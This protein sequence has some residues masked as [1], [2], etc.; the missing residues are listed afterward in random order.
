MAAENSARSTLCCSQRK[1][2]MHSCR[3]FDTNFW[4]QNVAVGHFKATNGCFEW[5]SWLLSKALPFEFLLRSNN[6]TY[7]TARQTQSNAE[8]MC[9]IEDWIKTVIQFGWFLELKLADDAVGN[10]SYTV[11]MKWDCW[12]LENSIGL[13]LDKV[14]FMA[15]ELKFI[16]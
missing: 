4:I 6:L 9:K 14:E 7:T 13:I 12:E 10:V 2:S 16:G 1:K 5:I 15:P 8:H 11:R 3:L